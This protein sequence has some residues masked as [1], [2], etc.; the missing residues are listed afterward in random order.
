MVFWKPSYLCV[1]SLLDVMKKNISFV[2]ILCLISVFE[3]SAQYAPR[4]TSGFDLGTGYQDNRWAPS[5]L[6]HQSLHFSK[7]PW[8]RIGWGVRTYGFYAQR[9]TLLSKEYNGKSDTLTLNQVSNT[10]VNFVLGINLKL[11]KFVDIGANA[12]L[13]G[14]AFGIKRSALYKMADLSAAP[15][16]ILGLNN[17]VIKARPS[18][19]NALPNLVKGQNGQGEAYIRLWFNQRIGL[20]LGYVFTQLAYLS[21]NKMNHGNRSFSESFG[22][23]YAAL[24]FSSF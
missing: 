21:P 2:V 5:F 17:T 7:S 14:L 13:A 12:D 11:A 23:P 18:S 15:D 9:T 8:L 3:G 24:S 10:G 20:K 4:V 6:Y 22:M 19:F 1:R 16:S